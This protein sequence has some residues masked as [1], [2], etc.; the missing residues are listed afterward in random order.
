MGDESEVLKRRRA[1]AEAAGLRDEVERL[2]AERARLARKLEH[3][4]ALLYEL[5]AAGAVNE[6][7][8]QQIED[9]MAFDG[10]DEAS[11]EPGWGDFDLFSDADSPHEA[12]D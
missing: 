4:G 9:A 10:R 7:V 5:R 6:H 11:G 2:T 3:I 1:E 8:S 12:G